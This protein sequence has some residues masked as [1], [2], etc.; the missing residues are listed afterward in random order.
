[1]MLA[2]TIVLDD[3]DIAPPVLPSG[4]KD[5]RN[6]DTARSR[7]QSFAVKTVTSKFVGRRRPAAIM[8]R[9]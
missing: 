3:R 8:I 5:G 7:R 6:S 1:M 2:L 9:S 4:S